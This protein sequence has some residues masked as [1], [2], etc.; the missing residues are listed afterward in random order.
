M[1]RILPLAGLCAV[2]LV[3]ASCPVAGADAAAVDAELQARIDAAID[4]GVVW[5]KARQRQDGGYP[6]F[7][8]GLPA[9]TYNPLDV[10]VNALVM[11][12]L[13]HCGVDREDD[14]IKKCL[15]FCRF[16][17]A[18]GKGS[19]NLKGNNK[20]YV[21]IAA[22]L[23]LALDAINADGHPEE[24]VKRDRYGNAIPQKPR[25]CKMPSQDQK[26]IRE[27]VDLIVRCQVKASG[28][29]RY[30]GNPVDSEPSDTDLSNTQYALLALDVAD[31]CGI[32]APDDTWLL[33]AEHVLREQGPRA[34]RFPC[35]WRTR[36]G[37]PAKRAWT[38]FSR[39]GRPRHGDGA[40]CR[41]NPP[42]RRDR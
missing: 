6:A 42:S 41:D 20:I 32:T 19:W 34:S 35:G 8:D 39:S 17:Y 9:N 30:P 28:G 16:H 10:G 14:A 33:A 25:P 37:N 7:G 15:S 38:A 11:Q 5:L 3:G 12:T 31:R 18:G 40:T 4:R 24:K 22:T 21:Y 29:W 2:L 13:A 23:I 27:L 26:W 36:R 1:K